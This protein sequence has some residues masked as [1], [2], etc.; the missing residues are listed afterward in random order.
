MKKDNDKKIRE[1]ELKKPDQ[2]TGPGETS[3]KRKDQSSS[4]SDKSS[5]G[6][7]GL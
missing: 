6:K 2:V 1:Q 4:E 3:V 7:K 5:K